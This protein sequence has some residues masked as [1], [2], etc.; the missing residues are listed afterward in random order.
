M[1]TVYKVP[2]QI[3]LTGNILIA[4]E[5]EEEALEIAKEQPIGTRDVID[6]DVYGEETWE[7]IR[8]AANCIEAT[9]DYEEEEC[10]NYEN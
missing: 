2:V 1:K 9:D 3:I 5:S 8:S 7:V 6:R 10:I 4:A